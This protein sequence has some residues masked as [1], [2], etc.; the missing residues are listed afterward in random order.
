MSMSFIR[1]RIKKPNFFTKI[2]LTIL[3]SRVPV[4]SVIIT[5]IDVSPVNDQQRS[6]TIRTEEKR[7][8]ENKVRPLGEEGCVGYTKVPSTG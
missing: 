3:G 5:I 1:E 2:F 4:L 7:Y 8:R 6:H